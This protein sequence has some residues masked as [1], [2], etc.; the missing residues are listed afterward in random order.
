VDFCLVFLVDAVV[1]SN[2]LPPP[3][4]ALHKLTPSPG[5]CVVMVFG[6]TVVVLGLAVMTTGG[7]VVAID[8][9]AVVL[10]SVFLFVVD[11]VLEYG[12]RSIIIGCKD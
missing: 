7:L 10:A 9:G 1:A 4:K 3:N 6:L 8:L 5:A 11:A 2:K 12:S